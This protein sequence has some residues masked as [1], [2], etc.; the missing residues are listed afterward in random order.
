MSLTF[1][2]GDKFIEF[3]IDTWLSVMKIHPH[4]SNHFKRWYFHAKEAQRIVAVTALA[5]LGFELPLEEQHD[6]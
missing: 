3:L 2:V 5:G 4:S 1:L 6:T